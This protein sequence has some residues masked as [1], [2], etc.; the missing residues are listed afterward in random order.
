MSI[1]CLYLKFSL[2][3]GNVFNINV[4]CLHQVE[5][6]AQKANLE[7]KERHRQR[8]WAFIAKRE[9]PKVASPNHS[10]VCHVHLSGIHRWPNSSALPGTLS[11]PTPKG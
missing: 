6:G 11:W 3:I 9:V 7:E 1:G 8:L 2:A 10:Y 5:G 4:G